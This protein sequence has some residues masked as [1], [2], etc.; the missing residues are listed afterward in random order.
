MPVSSVPVVVT[1]ATGFI[2]AEV[3]R[4]LL[5]A[6]YSVRGTTRDVATARASGELTSLPG[7]DDRLHLME[8]DL[9]GG[10]LAEVVADAEYVIHVASP[11]ALAVAD[12][13]RDLVD[14]AVNG[15][16]SILEAAARAGSTKRVV[17]TSSFAAIGSGSRETPYTEADW[18]ESAS[19]QHSPYSYSKVRAERAAWEF[20][21]NEDPGFDLV[22]VNPTMVFG[23]TLVRRVNQSHAFFIG[24]TDGSAPAIVA[25]D[26]P[27]V[28][29]RDVARAHILAMESPA[30]TGRYLLAAG[31][32]TPARIVDR[33]RRLGIDDRFRLPRLRLDRGLGVAL[34]RAVIP[35]QP[36]GNRG[37][38]RESLGKRWVVDGSRAERDL[39]LDYRDL[40]QT[41][42]DT[43]TSLD[44]WGLLGR[45]A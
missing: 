32:F 25:I 7:A 2:A 31:N 21:E 12:P 30:A 14:P 36:R 22:S 5:E 15:T 4:Q 44:E 10:G 27:M 18:N 45:R 43:W 17:L 13:Q 28:D 41:I 6:G 38:L 39:G 40:D 20:M 16:R 33:A 37:F 42:D 24:L 19:L 26:H 35:F 34:S 9:L 3:V 23:P 8:A 11:Y 1:G 29:V